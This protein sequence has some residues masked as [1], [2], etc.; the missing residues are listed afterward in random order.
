[1]WIFIHGW[2]FPL[3][4]FVVLPC[5]PKNRK[6]PG[7]SQLKSREPTNRLKVGDTLG[8]RLLPSRPTSWKWKK[9]TEK[10]HQQFNMKA[11]KWWFQKK[12]KR[13]NL[14]NF[15]VNPPIFSFDLFKNATVF[16]IQKPRSTR[17]PADCWI[18]PHPTCQRWPQGYFSKKPCSPATWII[19]G[20]SQMAEIHGV[21][22]STSGWP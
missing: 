6:Y 2:N 4:L 3:F 8:G 20:T 15:A 12:D 21:S 13:E 19:P 1:M 14:L 22:T 16:S 17:S 7:K 11:G 10:L 5:I 9:K 18:L